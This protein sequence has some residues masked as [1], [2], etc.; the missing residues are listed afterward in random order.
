[1]LY[2]MNDASLAIPQLQSTSWVN[3]R[4]PGN[5]LHHH[6]W[7]SIKGEMKATVGILMK[8]HLLLLLLFHQHLHQH[9][10][11]PQK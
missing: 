9:H 5:F 7:Y 3:L 6:K 11:V 4:S 10:Q 1:M 8:N 2:S